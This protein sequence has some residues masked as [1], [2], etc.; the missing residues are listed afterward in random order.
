MG[1]AP[2]GLYFED[3][4]AGR[5]WETAARTI[6]EADVTAFAGLTG[7]YTYLHTDAEAASSRPSATASRM[8]FWGSPIC[9]DLSP[10]WVS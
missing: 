4:E 8:A 9:P 7:D 2:T 1:N 3:F 10:G 5:I 6:G